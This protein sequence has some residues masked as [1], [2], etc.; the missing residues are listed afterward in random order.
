MSLI[1]IAI[2][3]ILVMDPL[4]NIPVFLSVLKDYNEKKQVKIIL[5]ETLIAFFILV[6]FLFFGHY[7]MR[8]LALSTSALSIAGG[9]ILFLIAL[10]MIFPPEKRSVSDGVEQKEEEPF[11]VP[12]AVPLTAGPSA[13][14]TVLLFSSRYSDHTWEI[15]MAVIIAT[16][17][18][19]FIM[20]VSRWL[21]RFLGR[22]GLIA[23]ER[24]MGMILTTVAVQMFLSGLL[25]YWKHS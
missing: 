24:L 23:I 21:M 25:E 17:F 11:I 18:F 22:R 12:L 3:L 1:A 4:G 9:I 16:A 13:I 2:T 14:A 19:L 6:I 5:R 10:R 20:L 7:I 15:L 8:G